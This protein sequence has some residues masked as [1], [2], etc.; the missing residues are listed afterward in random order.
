LFLRKLFFI[1]LWL[2]IFNPV[3][4]ETRI[5]GGQDAEPDA[6]PWMVAIVYK[7]EDANQSIFCGGALI[8]PSW[9][10]TAHH[11]ILGEVAEE[12]D[13]VIDRNT[14]DEKTVGERIHVAEIVGHPA[15][16]HNDPDLPPTSDVAL[17]RLEKPSTRPIIKLADPYSSDLTQVGKSATVMGWGKLRSSSRSFPDTLQQV[18]L[19]IVSN[20]TC[21]E[22]FGGD[23]SDTMLCAGPKEGGK[24]ACEGDSGGPLVVQENGEW[25]Q[26]GIVSFGEGCASPDFYGVYTRVSEFRDFVSQ[27]ICQVGDTPVPPRLELVIDN[28]EATALWYSTVKIDGYYFYYAPY[29]NPVSEITF[30]NIYGFDVDTDTEFSAQLFSG[31]AYYTAV[32]AYQGNCVSEYSNIGTVIIP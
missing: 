6:W 14:L 4:A 15:Y 20:E 25:Y 7:G 8:H 12:L 18:T 16:R 10:L 11:C 3:N 2:T 19:P 27:H 24:D 32:R 29:S 13:V 9:V 5:V 26:V 22:A 21:N 30:D 1:S 31:A 28:Q 23:I 17:L